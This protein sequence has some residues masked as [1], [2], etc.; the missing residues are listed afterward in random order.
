M[1]DGTGQD[2]RRGDVRASALE[3]DAMPRN[4]VG[5][6]ACNVGAGAGGDDG[7]VGGG[8]RMPQLSEEA[9]REQNM[10]DTRLVLRWGCRNGQVQLLNRRMRNL[11][12]RNVGPAMCAWIRERVEWE[13]S[14]HLRERRDGVLVVDVDPAGEGSVDVRLEDARPAPRLTRETLA[15]LAGGKGRPSLDEAR[16]DAVPEEPLDGLHLWAVAPEGGICRVNAGCGEARSAIDRFTC[17]LAE[18]MGFAIF[19]ADGG[20][21]AAADLASAAELASSVSPADAAGYFATSEE[22]GIVVCEGDEGLEIVRRLVAC[23]D[24]LW[25]QGS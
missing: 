6:G 15:D 12:E 18:T 21:A 9:W 5:G 3:D 7:S 4:V 17:D 2:M 20:P 8:P 13:M 19:G 24:K 1:A 16:R 10:P 25:A 11:A 14:G 23:F 22:W